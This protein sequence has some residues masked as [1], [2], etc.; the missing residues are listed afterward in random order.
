MIA[1]RENLKLLPPFPLVRHTPHATAL[2]L[3][4]PSPPSSSAENCYH[5]IGKSAE[6]I[7]NYYGMTYFLKT[8]EYTS[9]YEAIRTVCKTNGYSILPEFQR[10]SKQ[11]FGEDC[12]AGFL[13]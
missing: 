2:F 6:E 12:L 3:L 7:A 5:L 9:I 8:M 1:G 10:L 11:Y 13:V 4:S